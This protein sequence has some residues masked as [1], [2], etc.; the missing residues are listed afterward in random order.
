[1]SYGKVTYTGDAAT[2]NFSVTFDYILKAHVKVYVDGTLQ[3]LTTDYTWFNSTTIEFNSAPA[4]GAVILFERESSPAT[5][6][7]DF[8]DAS[9]LTE[10]SL[11]RAFDQMFYMAQEAVD[12]SEDALLLDTDDKYDANSKVIKDVADAVDNGDAVNLGVLLGYY[13]STTEPTAANITNVP[14]G[15]IAASDVQTALNELDSEKPDLADNNVWTGTQTFRDNKLEV[16]DESDTTKK[17]ALDVGTNVPTATTVTL[18]APAASGTLAVTDVAQ[19]FSKQQTPLKAALTSSASI[20]WDAA[21]A[22]VATLSLAH[23]ATLNAPTNGVA[24]TFYCLAVTNSGSYTLAFNSTFL[25]AD[26][27]DPDV[28]ASGKDFFTFFYDGSNYWCVGSVQALA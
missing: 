20:D 12:I 10:A 19:V 13:T 14:A 22:Q 25:F 24:G 5:K 6:L 4:D 26:G 28:T 3:T 17:L 21:A 16:T 18:K 7:V 8:Q 2:T 1:M 27:V 11:D 23:N 9:T 15:N